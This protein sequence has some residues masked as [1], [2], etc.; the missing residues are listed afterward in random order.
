MKQPHRR[1]RVLISQVELYTLLL[2]RNDGIQADRRASVAA[3]IADS[4]WCWLILKA[5]TIVCGWYGGSSWYV[6]SEQGGGDLR[7]L[8]FLGE[9]VDDI[10]ELTVFQSADSLVS[11]R[12][13]VLSQRH[14]K[15]V[16]NVPCKGA[17]H[18]IEEAKMMGL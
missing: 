11:F 6:N 17:H 1:R 5:S 10:G 18:N 3:S 8:H 14:R 12:K 15:I 4:A 9:S 16:K 2:L 13:L 7:S